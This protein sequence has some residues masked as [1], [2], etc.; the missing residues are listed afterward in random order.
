MLDRDFTGDYAKTERAW[1]FAEPKGA[2]C[3]AGEAKSQVQTGSA[4]SAASRIREQAA[5]VS[6]EKIDL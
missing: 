3:F 2:S 5:S 6:T 4:A 1:A